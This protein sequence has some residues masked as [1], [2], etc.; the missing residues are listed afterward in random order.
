MSF[1]IVYKTPVLKPGRYSILPS[2]MGGIFH[3]TVM[4]SCKLSIMQ[5][6][7]LLYRFVQETRQLLQSGI[8]VH[9][10]VRILHYREQWFLFPT[11][12]R[13]RLSGYMEWILSELQLILLQGPSLLQPLVM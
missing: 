10:T 13:G 5:P 2:F 11:P 9:G 12:N 6:E 7:A 8:T 4:V 1:Q 3:W